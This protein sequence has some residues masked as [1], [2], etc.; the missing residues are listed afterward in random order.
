MAIPAHD[1]GR[2]GGGTITGIVLVS[3]WMLLGL[4]WAFFLGVG[5]SYVCD[6]DQ[7][8]L[9]R[10][11][12]RWAMMLGVV[13]LSILGTILLWIGR[14]T[15]P[16]GFVLGLLGTGGVAIAFTILYDDPL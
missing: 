3:I 2:M 11:R 6:G 7:A 4:G 5:E 12:S 1:R 9:D 13:A 14:R 16:W 10:Y 8:C 15:R